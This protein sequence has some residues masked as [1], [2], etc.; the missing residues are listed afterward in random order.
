MGDGNIETPNNISLLPV[1]AQSAD[2]K[3][4]EICLNI[5]IN[6]A[7][8]TSCINFREIAFWIDGHDKL[9]FYL[10]KADSICNK[11]RLS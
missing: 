3:F 11:A 6:D 5:W 1:S 8:L 10:L 7:L 2:C 4:K 9:S